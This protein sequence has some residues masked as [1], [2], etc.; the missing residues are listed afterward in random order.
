MLTQR[1]AEILRLLAEDRDLRDIAA[2]LQVSYA[3]VR[4]HVQHILTK[5]SVHSIL[6]AVACHILST[7]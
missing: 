6:E 2:S 4:N 7:D 3:T 1:E 5:L